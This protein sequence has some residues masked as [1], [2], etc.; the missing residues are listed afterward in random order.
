MWNKFITWPSPGNLFEGLNTGLMG[1]CVCVYYGYCFGVL[2]FHDGVK[3][4]IVTWLLDLLLE[5]MSIKNN[6]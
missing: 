5:M 1:V 3:A 6:M 4:T 2:F